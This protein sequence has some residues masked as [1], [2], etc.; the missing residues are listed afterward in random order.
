MYTSLNYLLLVQLSLAPA[1]QQSNGRLL[2]LYDLLD[3]STLCCGKE[4][5]QLGACFSASWGS[6]GR[7]ASDLLVDLWEDPPGCLSF[8]ISLFLSF[9]FYHTKYF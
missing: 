2:I 6:G 1:T 3:H 8:P 7:A 4:E 9:G 5:E